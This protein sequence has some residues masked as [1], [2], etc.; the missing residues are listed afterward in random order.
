[1][2]KA[3]LP[4][5][6][7][8]PEAV[9]SMAKCVEFLGRGGGFDI[10]EAIK[11]TL[12][13]KPRMF[14]RMDLVW[15]GDSLNRPS[16]LTVIQKL[17]GMLGENSLPAW[18]SVMTTDPKEIGKALDEAQAI[19]REK[20]QKFGNDYDKNIWA[21]WIPF[22]N[23][24]DVLGQIS[25]DDVVDYFYGTGVG[26]GNKRYAK[27]FPKCPAA[28]YVD[29]VRFFMEKDVSKK[30]GILDEIKAKLAV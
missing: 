11:K 30:N 13:D 20:Y 2:G 28:I 5:G 1:M 22:G 8:K 24:E 3:Q 19:G 18:I 21:G 26:F 9:S 16:S 6:V 12:P 27:D 10:V 7:S 29:A 15:D 14:Y 4:D 23:A 25:L 17:V